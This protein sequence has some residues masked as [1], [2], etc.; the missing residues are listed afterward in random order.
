MKLSIIIPVFNEKETIKEVLKRVAA[1]PVL[2]YE[3]EIIVVDDGSNDGSGEILESLRKKFNFIYCRHSKNC[4]K[5]RAIRTALK[6]VTGDLVLIQDADLEYSPNDY[7]KLLEVFERDK[8]IV[9][10]S[11]NI[12]PKKRGYFHY[13]LGV[14]FLTFVVNLLFGSKLTDV[15]TCYKLLPSSL[16]KS[17][18]LT[19]QR[20]EFEAEITAKILK[21]GL[22]IKEIPIDYCPRKFYQGKKIRFWDG[23]LGFWTI[24]KYWIV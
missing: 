18:Q 4:G 9:Y 15:Y 1:A 13:V 20:F 5:G 8:S 10:G 14:K 23:L 2:G 24:L 11:R 12:N 3:K 7:Q 22:I 21:R 16:I 6:E 17:I 19:S